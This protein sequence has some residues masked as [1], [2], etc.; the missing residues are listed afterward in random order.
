MPDWLPSLIDV[1]PWPDY[2]YEVL[3][4]VFCRDIRNVTFRYLGHEVWFY[5]NKEDGKEAIFWHLTTRRPKKIPRRKS[6]FYPPGQVYDPQD[7]FPD[8]PRCAR[9]RWVRPITENAHDQQ[10]LSW[11]YVESDGGIHTYAWLKG[12]DFVVILEKRDNE[13]RRL[14]TSFYV[15]YDSKRDDLQRKY[16]NRIQ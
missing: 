14:I 7:R 16:E 5:R 2:M 13:S 1:D 6:K 11:D 3:Y 9:L 10:V 8:P 15:D 4:K 12:D